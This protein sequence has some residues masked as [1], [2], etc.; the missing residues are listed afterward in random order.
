MQITSK[1]LPKSELELT[2]ELSAEE[3]K[4]FI[5]KAAVRL[6]TERAIEGFRAGK[7]PLD[8]VI[9]KFGQ[10]M[11]DQAAAEEAV[12]STYGKAIVEQKLQPIGS[13]SVD[14]KKLAAGNPFIYTATV[15]LLPEVKLT[16]FSGI[17]IEKKDPKV[18]ETDV[19]R[20]VLDL[21]NSRVKEVVVARPAT[22]A[23]KVIVDMEMK[24]DGVPLEGG[25][26]KGHHVFMSE[27]HYIPGF[28]EE[29]VGLKKDDTKTFTLKFPKEHY[30]KNVAGMPVEF[31]IK[32]ADVFERQLPEVNDEFAKSFG[33]TTAAELDKLI[34]E[35]LLAESTQKEEQRQEIAAMEEI[36]KRSKFGDIP[37]L[38]INEEV[39]RMIFELRQGLSERSLNWDEYLKKAGKTETQLKLDFVPQ[40]IDRIKAALVVRQIAIENNI[41]ADETEVAA[42][43][44]RQMNLYVDDAATQEK[45]RSEDYHERMHM[46]LRNRKVVQFIKE[47]VVR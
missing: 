22:K 24:K 41:D 7:A 10:G 28:T 27:E 5:E 6:S 29:L 13:P 8:I 35:N 11:V 39:G 15:V 34:R 43:I 32:V 19:E 21:R 12:R 17:K 25:Q 31:S 47:K 16:D 33:Q 38:L 23:D 36:V 1:N 2:I 44:A 3:M 46:M 30:Q 26:A 14:V 42:E 40:A 18:P 20:A 9:K 4:P 45:I 37:E